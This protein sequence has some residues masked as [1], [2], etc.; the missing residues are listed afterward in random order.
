MRVTIASRIY[1]PEAAAA[2]FRLT[3]LAGA[4]ADTG[5]AVKVLT[6]SAPASLREAARAT[7][8]A[9]RGV[10]VRRFPV[11]RDRDDYVRG[12]V[13]YL[14]FDGPLFF[15]LLTGRRPD[16]IVVEPPPTTGLVARIAAGIRR[17]PY[18]YYAADVWS[19]ATASMGA[20]GIVTRVLRAVE[21]FALRG[22]AQVIAVSDGVAERVRDI[23]GH[24]RVTVVRNGIDTSVFTP[25]GPVDESAPTAVYAGTMSEWQGADVFVRAWPAVLERVP[26]A[27]LVFA[28][29]GSARAELQSLARELG[30]EA[31]VSFAGVVPPQEAA[32]LLRSARVGLVSITPGQ[33][34]DF[35]VPTKL[36]A[37]AACG[38]PVIFAGGGPPADVVREGGI[39]TVTAHDTDAV[40]MALLAALTAG[41][42]HGRHDEIADWARANVSIAAVGQAAADAVCGVV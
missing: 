6:T 27:R 40:A 7:D 17:V 23:A 1:S 13:Q 12:Y 33:G 42:G 37:A 36:F 28:G 18:V 39:G 10:S 35:A 21:R 32:R 24:D 19:D 30:V 11:L 4:L 26:D 29:G 25:D 2:S 14:S 41:S 38:T 22:A 5:H 15:R 34:Y 3:A 20:P 31:S 8:S 9:R 16:A